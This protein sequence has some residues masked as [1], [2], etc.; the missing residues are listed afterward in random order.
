MVF[1]IKY[2]YNGSNKRNIILNW[3][4]IKKLRVCLSIFLGYVISCFGSFFINIEGM[5]LIKH[6]ITN[7][8]TFIFFIAKYEDK[9]VAI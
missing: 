6:I 1:D 5:I 9:I 7:Y 8:I 4:S 2:K 3:S